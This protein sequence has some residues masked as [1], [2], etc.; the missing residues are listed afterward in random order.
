MVACLR[1]A[2][3]LSEGADCVIIGISDIVNGGMMSTDVSEGVGNS[4]G[5]SGVVGEII[6]SF[7]LAFE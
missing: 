3:I 2:P 5:G 7:T 1:F 6:A 4:A